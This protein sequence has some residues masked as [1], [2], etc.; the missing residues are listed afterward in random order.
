VEAPT[1]FR[2]E[3]HGELKSPDVSLISLITPVTRPRKQRKV[4]PLCRGSCAEPSNLAL[5]LGRTWREA[6]VDVKSQ[7]KLLKAEESLEL[8][9][10]LELER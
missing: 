10:S 3:R 4:F 6:I 5:I 2:L 8:G 1:D 7:E 9:K